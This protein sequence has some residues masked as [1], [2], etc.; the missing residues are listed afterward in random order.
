M[1]PNNTIYQGAYVYIVENEI[2]RRRDIEIAWQNDDEAIIGAGLQP[3]DVLVTTALGQVTSGIRV[4]IVGE[5]SE[6]RM[7]RNQQEV[8]K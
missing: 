1:I 2:L 3:G 6:R 5:A 7:G 8:R 4:T